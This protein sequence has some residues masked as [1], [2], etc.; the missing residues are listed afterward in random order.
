MTNPN[1]PAFPVDPDSQRHQTAS[2]GLLLAGLTK[3]EYFI[4]MAINVVNWHSSLHDTEV[5]L[6][7]I[8]EEAIGLADAIIAKLNKSQGAA[9]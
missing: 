7:I 1:D 5:T 3:R 6:E 8:A 9:K 4:A 2:L